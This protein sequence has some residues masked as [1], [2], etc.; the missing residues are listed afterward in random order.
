LR[1]RVNFKVQV[2]GENMNIN[3]QLKRNI[4][5]L[6]L[7]IF[8]AISIPIIITN[9][10]NGNNKTIHILIIIGMEL[11]TGIILAISLTNSI[12]EFII[13]HQYN[14]EKLY[15]DDLGKYGLRISVVL[16][17]LMY[18]FKNYILI[19]GIH[20]NMSWYSISFLMLSSTINCIYMNKE[21]LYIK[22][23][24][25]VIPYKSIITIKRENSHIAKLI[26]TMGD[27]NITINDPNL[28]RLQTK[29]ATHMD[30]EHETPV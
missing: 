8:Y 21:G 19:E 29:V 15:Y 11:L 2:L 13:V 22:D 20:I 28:K 9:L 18:G 14:Y 25:I 24:N 7:G 3:K 12:E 10:I 17:L 5:F 1:K 30:E 27:Y 26:S 6:L 23:K 4:R 16:A